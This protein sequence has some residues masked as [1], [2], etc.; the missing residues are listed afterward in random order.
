[1]NIAAPARVPWQ[2]QVRPAVLRSWASSRVA[3]LGIIVLGAILR[4]G[5]LGQ[6]SIWLDEAVVV[7][8]AQHP[9]AAIPRLLAALDQH[10]PGYYLLMH[11]W[12]SMAVLRIKTRERARRFLTWQSQRM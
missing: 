1:M 2:G 6:R 7:S 4:I 5:F 3:L 8:V 9:W 11:V 10:P 12:Q